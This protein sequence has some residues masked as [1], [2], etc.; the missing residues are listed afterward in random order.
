MASPFSEK[1]DKED[2]NWLT[3]FSVASLAIIAILLINQ[4]PFK[5]FALNLLSEESRKQ[6]KKKDSIF[7]EEWGLEND[8]SKWESEK[9]RKVFV[10]DKDAKARGQ[11]TVKKGFDSFTNDKELALARR[12]AT[13]QIGKMMKLLAYKNKADTGVRLGNL[14]INITKPRPA[15][16]QN[17]VNY[18]R[19]K[20]TS[21]P[22]RYK[23][24]PDLALSWDHKGY[25]QI[26]TKRLKNYEYFKAMVKKVEENFHPPGGDPRL[27]WAQGGN[28]PGVIRYATFVPQIV[29][30]VFSIDRDGNV[31]EVRLQ[32]SR[33][34]KRLDEA[35]LDSIRQSKNFGPPPVDE[36]ENDYL[37]VP[38]A[39]RFGM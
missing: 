34:N 32:R 24:K 18:G 4:L 12:G 22:L 11:L 31:D 3:F 39:F 23:W 30:V 25:P 28:V 26:P 5:S 38:F 36:L 29:Y 6:K 19:S 9:K 7:E 17:I 14:Q 37:I 8:K 33:G 13:S 20:F 15:G 2:R 27:L 35:C 10:S 1:L 16:S 21:I